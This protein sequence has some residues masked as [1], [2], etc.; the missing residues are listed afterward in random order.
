MRD[1]VATATTLLLDTDETVVTGRGNV[2]LADETFFLDLRPYP[3]RA[4]SSRFGVPLEIRG[5]FAN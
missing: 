3:K 1:G 2:N 4:G 5:T